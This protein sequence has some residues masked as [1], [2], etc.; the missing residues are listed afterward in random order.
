MSNAE[1]QAALFKQYGLNWDPSNPNSKDNDV[2]IHKH[3]KIITRTGIQ[4]IERGAGIT[5]DI[6]IVDSAKDYVIVQGV[7]TTKDGITYKTLASATSD[8]SS[9]GYYAEM[10]EK[11]CRSRL[12]LTLAGL[13]ELGVFGEDEAES[14]SQEANTGAT[15]KGKYGKS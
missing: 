11:R 9:N 7:G 2:F 12:I 8:T 1:I 5:C 3:Y 15:Y 13:Y 4:K 6:T 14:F 10:A